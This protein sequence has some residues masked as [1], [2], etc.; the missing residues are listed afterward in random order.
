MRINEKLI[1][2]IYS[3][4]S[5]SSDPNQNDFSSLAIILYYIILFYIMLYY[6]ILYFIMHIYVCVCVCNVHK[7]SDDRNFLFTKVY[8]SN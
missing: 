1:Q 8:S 3:E 7:Y 6:I 4:G 2:V 5:L